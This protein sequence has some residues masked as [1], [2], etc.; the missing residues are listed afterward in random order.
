MRDIGAGH[1][2][3]PRPP[4][5]PRARSRAV[6]FGFTPPFVVVLLFCCFG[7]FARY[8]GGSINSPPP[9]WTRPQR[10]ALA[11]S[12]LVE[13]TN[14]FDLRHADPTPAGDGGAMNVPG[15]I[16]T[17][18]DSVVQMTDLSYSVPV[19]PPSAAARFPVHIRACRPHHRCAVRPLAQRFAI[20]EVCQTT[21]DDCRRCAVPYCAVPCCAVLCC[22]VLCCALPLHVPCGR[23]PCPWLRHVF[24]SSLTLSVS[25]S[26]SLCHSVTLAVPMLTSC[27]FLS[28]H[29]LCVSLPLCISTSVSA[30]SLCLPVSLSLFS[31][32]VSRF[33]FLGL[34]ERRRHVAALRIRGR[35]NT[36][37][38][39]T[40]PATPETS[41]ARASRWWNTQATSPLW[42]V[43]DALK[44]CPKSLQPPRYRPDAPSFT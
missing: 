18:I 11:D 36:T 40:A 5:L 19:S 6:W 44:A 12:I 14:T 16:L 39:G 2:R 38:T 24:L 21:H 27:T 26:L 28:P 33:L 41:T 30:V 29:T 37:D 22:A 31:A 43:G 42:A 25:A 3:F 13:Y 32:S 34:V 7:L 15:G 10:H 8:H 35:C 20:G 4:H 1:A 17:N 23:L 9:V